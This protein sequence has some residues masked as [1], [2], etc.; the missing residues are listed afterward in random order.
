MTFIM[1]QQKGYGLD[2]YDKELLNKKEV[3]LLTKTD[4][5]DEKTV[6]KTAR[7]LEKLNKKVIPTSIYD[8]ESINLLLK[9][10]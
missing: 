10:L 1:K 4:M 9:Y 8:Q 7:E 6:K 3:I 5:V 2:E